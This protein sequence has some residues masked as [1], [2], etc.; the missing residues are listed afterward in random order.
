MHVRA[1]G[2]MWTLRFGEGGEEVRRRAAE[3]VQ[4]QR[5][6]GVV[7]RRVAGLA[8]L[9]HVQDVGVLQVQRAHGPRQQ[10]LGRAGD[11][12]HSY[13]AGKTPVD[14][15]NLTPGS[16]CDNQNTVQSMTASMAHVTN[17]VTPPGSDATTLPLG[18]RRREAQGA[19]RRRPLPGLHRWDPPG[20][21]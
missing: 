2:G 6:A 16:G 4:V 20:A 7:H 5:A 8:R 1:R 3:A 15:T 11:T 17:R 21:R 9:P 10:A 19:A 12:F 14:V 13:F 18:H